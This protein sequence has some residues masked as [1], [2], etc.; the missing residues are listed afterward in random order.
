MKMHM[1]ALLPKIPP[2]NFKSLQ[3]E[4]I[5]NA[6]TCSSALSFHAPLPILFRCF[7]L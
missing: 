4:N 6:V 2:Q 3:R 7:R 5:I 1:K